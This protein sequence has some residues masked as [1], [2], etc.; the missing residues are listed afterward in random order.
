[1]LTIKKIEKE[2]KK[3]LVLIV[4]NKIDIPIINTISVKKF[5]NDTNQEF[6]LLTSLVAFCK[7]FS[8]ENFKK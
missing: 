3:I 2:N 7:K 5:I 6:K 4:I 8:D 1:M